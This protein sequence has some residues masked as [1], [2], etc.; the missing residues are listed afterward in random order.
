MYDVQISQIWFGWRYSLWQRSEREGL[1]LDIGLIGLAFA[2]LTID[3]LVKVN[4]PNDAPAVVAAPFAVASSLE[5]NGFGLTTRWG[6]G[7]EYL[8]NSWLGISAR[9]DYI[10]GSV[11]RLRVV[12]FYRPG[13]SVP[14]PPEAV[15]SLPPPPNEGDTVTYATVE[16]VGGNP[17]TESASGTA[18]LPLELNGLEIM[19]GIHFYF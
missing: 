3:T 11:P 17:N 14:P 13:F 16:R 15:I 7:G 18:P 4:N 12:R 1:Y 10:V 2:K 5:A 6:L 19:F 9:A 8:L